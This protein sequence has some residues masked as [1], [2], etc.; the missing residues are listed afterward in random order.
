MKTPH[1]SLSVG[2][3]HEGMIF[4]LF[5]ARWLAAVQRVF[6]P[7]RSVIGNRSGL[8]Q[9]TV[10]GG[11]SK[12]LSVVVVELMIRDSGEHTEQSQAAVKTEE[13]EN[14]R[15]FIITKTRNRLPPTH[16]QRCHDASRGRFAPAAG[17]FRSDSSIMGKIMYTAHKGKVFLR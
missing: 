8:P 11:G 6:I 13:A 12:T 17:K 7:R 1:R 5:P 2:V 3:V 10:L 14:I 9:Y 4:P 16:Y 15:V